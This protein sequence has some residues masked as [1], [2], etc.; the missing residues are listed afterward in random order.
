MI[1]G[2]VGGV[3]RTVGIRRGDGGGDGGVMIN[4]GIGVGGG[5]EAS[6][7]GGVGARG[8]VGAFETIREIGGV[9]AGVGVGRKMEGKYNGR[10]SPNS[11]IATCSS[12]G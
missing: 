5:D 11:A 3:T 6:E 9:E 10:K 1:G 12:C 8:G 2:G 7:E 4:T